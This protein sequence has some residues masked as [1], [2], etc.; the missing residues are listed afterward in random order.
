M[1]Y[2]YMYRVYRVQNGYVQSRVVAIAF[3]MFGTIL[4]S[5]SAFTYKH[6]HICTL[7]TSLEIIKYS[8]TNGEKGRVF[9]VC[10]D[11]TE[12]DRRRYFCGCQHWLSPN[13][14]AYG[15]SF[16]CSCSYCCLT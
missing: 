10:R 5:V 11:I 8:Q 3:L 14:I 9:G 16:C 2:T 13:A 6:T 4:V 7:F 1:K 12:L 15:S